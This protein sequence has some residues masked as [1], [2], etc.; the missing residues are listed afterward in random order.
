MMVFDIFCGMG[1]A[2]DGLAQAGHKV[3][4]IDNDQRAVASHQL[5][6]HISFN[7]DVSKITD[8]FQFLP[9]GYENE[10]DFGL[11]LSPPCTAFS[12]AG[13]GKGMTYKD[14]IIECIKEENWTPW[15]DYI[16]QNIWL[17]IEVGRW[18][19]MLKPK[20]VL[21]EQVIRA[22]ELWCAYEDK[23]QEW[24]YHT[25][26]GVLNCADYSL[27]QTR[28]RAFF[29]ASLDGPVGPPT[30]THAKDGKDGLLPWVTMADALGWSNGLVGFPRL[31]DGKGK[32][33]SIEIDGKNYRRRDMKDINE[34]SQT[35]T[36]KA[37]SWRRV[38]SVNTGADHRVKGDR[39]KSQTFDPRKEPAK[40]LTAIA[41]LQWNLE[42]A[43][44]PYSLPATTVVGDYRITSRSHHDN[45]GSQ[46]KNAKSTEDVQNGNYTLGQPI[47]LTIQEGLV[48]QGFDI[49]RKI[50]GTKTAK[51]KAIGNAVPPIMAKL[52]AES[53]EKE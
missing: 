43:P 14:D 34:P 9:E 22:K 3:I 28:K 18:T 10:K 49:N 52:L 20:W 1:G 27:P 13:K 46:G 6:G 37:R 29:I 45:E 25:W 24:G 2:S 39:S 15:A 35:V 30:Q 19:Q 33:E 40:T 11:W 4:G 7:E 26:S 31:D 8:P 12:V 51:F 44:W 47:K 17:P 53:L 42:E 23:F 41:G 48:L 36:E 5:G 50:A 21:C 38:E 16:D 32:E